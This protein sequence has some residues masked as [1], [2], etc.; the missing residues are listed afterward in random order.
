MWL[1]KENETKTVVIR[2]EASK[3]ASWPPRPEDHGMKVT[4]QG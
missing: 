2:C 1:K 3:L 4:C